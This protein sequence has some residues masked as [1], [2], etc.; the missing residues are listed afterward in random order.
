LFVGV[1]V[2]LL[3]GLFRLCCDFVLTLFSLCVATTYV[4]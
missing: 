2:G 3:V 4:A 1:L